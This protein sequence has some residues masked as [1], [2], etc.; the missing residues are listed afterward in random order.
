MEDEA[1]T[2]ALPYLEEITTGGSPFGSD[3]D[4][5]KA[6]FNKR[7]APMDSAEAARDALKQLKQGRD[8]VVEYQAKFNQFTAQTEWSDADH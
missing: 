3:Y 6:A 8:S 5:F 4:Q 1:R 2:W 7:F